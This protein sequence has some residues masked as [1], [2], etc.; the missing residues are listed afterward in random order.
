MLN[1]FEAFVSTVIDIEE[2]DIGYRKKMDN[3]MRPFDL[4][5]ASIRVLHRAAHSRHLAC[6]WPRLF[7]LYNIKLKEHS[8]RYTEDIRHD[9]D[10]HDYS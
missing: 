3:R 2:S 7:I 8:L 6:L 1:A 4:F 5:V 9:F 10:F